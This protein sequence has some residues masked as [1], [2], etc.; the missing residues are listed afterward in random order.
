MC[1]Y[2][3]HRLTINLFEV[4]ER[5]I[6]AVPSKPFG[7]SVNLFIPIGPNV[8]GRTPQFLVYVG[9][10]R[11][12]CEDTVPFSCAV[13]FS[14]GPN[15]ADIQEV[16]SIRSKGQNF[17]RQIN[18]SLKVCR[19]WT[20]DP[21]YQRS[22]LIVDP[23]SPSSLTFHSNSQPVNFPG[24]GAFNWLLYYY[25]GILAPSSQRKLVSSE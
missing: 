24:L 3:F 1:R 19:T 10:I 23:P 13:G 5:H 9:D 20:L 17:Q 8:S 18:S 12:R 21:R 4:L 11:S 25:R 14:A 2:L 7:S 6:C 22:H 15:K 16:E